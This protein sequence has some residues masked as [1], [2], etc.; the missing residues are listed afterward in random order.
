MS[1]S[2]VNIYR[3]ETGRWY[4]AAWAGFEFDCTDEMD[5]VESESEATAWVHAL[6]PEAQ[7]RRV[8]DL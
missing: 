4:F 1:I 5:D 8:A 2:N 7:V 3:D 6:W